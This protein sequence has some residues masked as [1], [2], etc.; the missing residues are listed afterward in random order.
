MAREAL[1]NP[2]CFIESSNLL[3]KTQIQKRTL[4]QLKQEFQDNCKLHEPREIYLKTIGKY[5]KWNN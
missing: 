2:D 1:V 5:C 3:N 4:E